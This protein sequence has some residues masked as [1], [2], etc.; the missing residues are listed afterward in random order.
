MHRDVEIFK[1]FLDFFAKTFHQKIIEFALKVFPK[2]HKSV[3]FCT[4]NKRRF[5]VELRFT[6]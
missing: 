4:D 3:K 6:T 1:N 2:F 5:Q